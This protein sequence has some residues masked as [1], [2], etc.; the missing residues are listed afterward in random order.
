MMRRTAEL[1]MSR[2]NL[3]LETLPHRF[4]LR[5][6]CRPLLERLALFVL[7]AAASLAVCIP[8]WAEGRQVGYVDMDRVFQQSRAGQQSKSDLDNEAAGYNRELNDINET[9][10]KVRE[11]LDKN[12]ITLS[13]RER[14]QREHR[15]AEL[16]S[17][18][19]RKKQAFAEEFAQHRDQAFADMLKRVEKATAKVAADEKLD[20]VINRAVTVNP[21]VD[22][23]DKVV[24]TLD[25]ASPASGD[26]K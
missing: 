3:S 6:A 7:A 4:E 9:A 24:R 16:K 5:N 26:A 1:T 13:D 12:S 19:D 8:A 14:S 20:V 23:T 22:I 2:M 17:Q 25:E 21:S 18:F 11:D 10:S 15:I